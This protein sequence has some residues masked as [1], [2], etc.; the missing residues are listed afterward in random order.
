[1]SKRFCYSSG[2]HYDFGIL[3][4]DMLCWADGL[5]RDVQGWTATVDF[6]QREKENAANASRSDR[7]ERLRLE[8]E[9]ENLRRTVR[10]LRAQVGSA[11]DELGCGGMEPLH[12]FPPLFPDKNKIHCSERSAVGLSQC[13]SHV[14]HSVIYCRA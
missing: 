8:A 13:G 2:Q 3:S 12:V 11:W 4:A 9:N 10:Q 14:A 5:E 1:M 7:E 6:L